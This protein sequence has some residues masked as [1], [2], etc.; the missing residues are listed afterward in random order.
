MWYNVI[1]LGNEKFCPPYCPIIEER[2]MRISGAAGHRG[3]AIWLRHMLDGTAHETYPPGPFRDEAAERYALEH[4]EPM[5]PQDE[6]LVSEWMADSQGT[7]EQV[8]ETVPDVYAAQAACKKG[9]ALTFRGKF[10]FLR[11]AVGSIFR[12]GMKPDLDD[13]EIAL[14]QHAKCSNPLAKAALKKVPK[15]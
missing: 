6:A 8:A 2:E 9:P 5:T 3:T 15:L 11:E 12:Y 1:M 14:M 10:V 7:I 13:R 4:T